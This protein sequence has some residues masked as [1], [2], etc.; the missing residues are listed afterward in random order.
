MKLNL[1]P[2]SMK[3]S[4]P[5]KAYQSLIKWW[6]PR[7]LDATYNFFLFFFIG[8][9]LMFASKCLMTW[10]TWS[11]NMAFGLTFSLQGLWVQI[12]SSIILGASIIVLTATVYDHEFFS[13][14]LALLGG[15]FAGWLVYSRFSKPQIEKLIAENRLVDSMLTAS[16]M[17]LICGLVIFALSRL[18]EFIENGQSNYRLPT[19][20][21]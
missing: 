10:L 13:G 6:G 18:A 7:L 1:I 14:P 12:V 17:A 2:E 11:L 9:C 19:R 5:R 20:R 8:L 4:A 21:Y 16:S 3:W 15:A